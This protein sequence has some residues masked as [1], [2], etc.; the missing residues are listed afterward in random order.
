MAPLLWAVYLTAEPGSK[1]AEYSQ[2][3][4]KEKGLPGVT[5]VGSGSGN[6]ESVWEG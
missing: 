1:A 5:Q 3:R 6:E 4:V 2:L